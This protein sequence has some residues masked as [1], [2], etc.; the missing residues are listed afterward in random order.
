MPHYIAHRKNTSADLN[1]TSEGYGI[2]MDIRTH[3]GQ[4]TIHHEPC[5]PVENCELFGEWL[6]TFVSKPRGTLILNV[7]EAG[8]EDRILDLMEKYAINDFFFLDQPA[9]YL[10]QWAAVVPEKMERMKKRMAVRVSQYEPI[11]GALALAGKVDWVWV[12]CFTELTLTHEESRRL[13]E[14]GFK[15]CL[16]SPELQGHDPISQIPAMF[17]L[18]EDRGIEM[19]AICTKRPDIWESLDLQKQ[20]RKSSNFSLRR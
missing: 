2:E 18:M 8:L 16:V 4:L 13:K 7:K 10:V 11:E 19:D 9:P 20:D 6:V 12:D 14:A 3:H 15:L 1:A 17:Q 5:E